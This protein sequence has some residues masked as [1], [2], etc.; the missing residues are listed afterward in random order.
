MSKALKCD[1]C[2]KYFEYQE[3]RENDVICA[4]VDCW[5]KV[6]VEQ[7]FMWEGT[8]EVECDF[9]AKLIDLCPECL[10]SFEGWFNGH[11]GEDEEES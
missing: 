10:D 2:G 3:P 5:G 6:K 4:T 7:W 11:A 9:V 8:K 1:R